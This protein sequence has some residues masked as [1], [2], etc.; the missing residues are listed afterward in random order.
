M[1]KINL[2]FDFSNREGKP[3]TPKGVGGTPPSRGGRLQVVGVPRGSESW[4]QQ[5]K[6][7]EPIRN[8][9]EER[10][11]VD[12]PRQRLFEFRAQLGHRG[13]IS[14]ERTTN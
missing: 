8:L 2:L 7:R 4:C 5:S 13:K 12:I 9:S 6:G 10:T 11:H 14:L 3:A 1:I